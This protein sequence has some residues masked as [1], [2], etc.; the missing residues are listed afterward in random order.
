MPLS[1][2]GFTDD[3]GNARYQRFANT[4]GAVHG[5][6]R[7]YVMTHNTDVGG[8]L[9]TGYFLTG[10]NLNQLFLTARRVFSGKRAHLYFG[11]GGGFAQGGDGVG[12]VVF[13]AHQYMLGMVEQFGQYQRPGDYIFVA[14]LHQNVIGRDV[15]FALSADDDQS[16]YLMIVARI[17]LDRCGITGATEPGNARCPNSAQ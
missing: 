17:E 14:G 5:G 12:L 10:E 6:S 4:H 11:T 16:V 3:G 8:D 13:H 7:A 15:G 2:P 1:W 9:S